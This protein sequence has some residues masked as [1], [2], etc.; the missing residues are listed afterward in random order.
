MIDPSP[1]ATLTAGDTAAASTQI[2]VRDK[3]GRAHV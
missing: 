2:L 3:I 1:P